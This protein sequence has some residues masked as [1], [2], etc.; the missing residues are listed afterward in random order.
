M[1]L[2]KENGIEGH[3]LEDLIHNEKLNGIV[4]RE[5]QQA[6]KDGG[7]SGIEIIDGVVMADEEWTAANVSSSA[8]WTYHR[9]LTYPL[10]PYNGSSKDQPKSHPGQV[11]KRSRQDLRQIRLKRLV[12]HLETALMFG[13]TRVLLLLSSGLVFSW[14]QMCASHF[15]TC[16]R[17]VNACTE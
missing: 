2:A 14:I 8:L 13:A 9:S 17:M 16:Q 5:M 3:G 6:G 4:L 10:G 11:P 12:F 1:K 15:L 7:L